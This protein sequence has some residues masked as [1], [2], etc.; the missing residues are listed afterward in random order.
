MKHHLCCSA[1]RCKPI[2]SPGCVCGKLQNP[3]GSL[4]DGQGLWI[5]LRSDHDY[6]DIIDSV[7]DYVDDNLIDGKFREVDDELAA[8]DLENMPMIIALAWL[9]ISFP[10]RDKLPSYASYLA[11]FRAKHSDQSLTSGL[12]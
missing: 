12:D 10:A 9:T 7:F 2:G 5:E 11:K 8:I 1:S 4:Q 3:D 6:D